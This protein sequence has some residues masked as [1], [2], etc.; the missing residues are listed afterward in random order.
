MRIYVTTL[1][2]TFFITQSLNAQTWRST[3]YPSDWTSADDKSFYTD[4]IIQDWSYAGYRRGEDPIP[5]IT[6]NIIDVTQAPYNADNSGNTDVTSKIQDAIDDAGN[7]GGG[8]VYMP[9]GTYQ[10]SKPSGKNYCLV[11]KKSNVVLRGAGTNNTFLYNSSND[12]RSDKIIYV[13]NGGNWSSTGSNQVDI[14]QD[15]TNPT[16]VI[17]V[18]DVSNYAPGDMVIVRNYIGTRWI[19]EHNMT[20]WW[21]DH[22]SSFSGLLYCREVMEVDVANK[23]LTIDIPIRYTLLTADDA[24]VYKLSSTMISEVG[25]EDFSIGNRDRTDDGWDENDYQSSSNGAYYT[26]ASWAI[27]L[28]RVVNCWVDNVSSYQ[29][30]GN[31][32]TSH[33]LSNGILLSE[34]K[35]V[36]LRNCH[37]QRPQFGG[38]GGNGYMYRISANESLLTNCTAEFQRHG[39]VVAH[40]SSSG[41]VFHQC[42]D[43]DGGKQT[44]L[45]GSEG[46]N[47][48]G[49]DHHMHFSHSMLYDQCTVTNSYFDVRY[50]PY[51]SGAHHGLTGAHSAFW[52]TMSSGN[53]G[54]AVRCQQGRYGYV[55]GTSGS[56]T[57]VDTD[58][59]YSGS[60]IATDPVDHTEGLGDGAMLEPASLY[61]D[62]LSKRLGL[63]I[64]SC[65]TASASSH[66]GNVPVNVLDNDLETRWSAEGDEE[67]LQFCF[68]NDS[69]PI[70]SLSMAFFSGDVRSSIFDVEVSTDGE[71]WT[72]V[73]ENVT[74][75]GSSLELEEFPFSETFWATHLRIIGHG[76]SV[77][78]WNSYTEVSINIAQI[79]Y[80]GVPHAV[81]GI[82]EFEDYNEGGRT[83]GFHDIDNI[84]EGGEYRTDG[85]D[86]EVADDVSGGYNVG[87]TEAGEWLKYT[88]DISS[89]ANYDITL[90][91]ASST[92]GGAVK[93]AI[94]DVDIT[95]DIDLPVTGDWQ[96][97]EDVLVPNILLP[98]GEHVVTLKVVE[99]G[100]N[101]NRMSIEP[102]TVT[103]VNASAVPVGR[104]YPTFIRNGRNLTIE[105]AKGSDVYVADLLGKAVNYQVGQ[106]GIVVLSN[107]QLPKGV[108]V[109]SISG[110]NGSERYQVVKE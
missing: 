24:G 82:V 66:D 75:S 26:N 78:L 49:S 73:Q 17:P 100:S 109:V 106:T 92:S 38:G 21:G 7:A 39:F 67:W 22:A 34:T 41:N 54:F 27:D 20:Q 99:A 87:W 10:V 62:Q 93:L 18:T 107:D 9:S 50:R 33:I 63:V 25:I 2:L 81:P 80:G 1:V 19:D 40:M 46:T 64:S 48:K 56:K 65:Q 13:S 94:D 32:S 11:L 47:G 88:I 42:T 37:F 90:R 89:E 101:L 70:K 53:Q 44:G 55:I 76:N 15:L 4:K 79:A 97:Y 86:I 59:F 36:T 30:S 104:V 5:N 71:T 28:R 29:P 16:R 98:A 96:E 35:N 108:L 12:M 105:A 72:S 6:T 85:V 61:E 31:T 58:E 57:T 51:G 23:T 103:S 77:N 74:S 60:A 110:D 68:G 95:S 3:L 43:K 84:N 45:S 91:T 14:T 52:N 102:S 69:V 8:V 83:V